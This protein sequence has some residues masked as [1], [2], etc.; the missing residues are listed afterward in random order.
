M[1]NGKARAMRRGGFMQSSTGRFF[2]G[3]LASIGATAVL[4][5]LFALIVGMTDASDGVIRVGSQLIKVVCVLLGVWMAVH[6]GEARGALRGALLGLLYMGAGVL[7]YAVCTRQQLSFM[8]YLMDVLI[9]VSIGGLGGM[10]RQ[11]QT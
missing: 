4:I 3:L 8:S 7:V 6:R 5:V 9:G 11:Q 2:K 1:A 10:V